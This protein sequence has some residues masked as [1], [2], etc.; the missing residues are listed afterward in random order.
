MVN[1][2]TLEEA[3]RIL[4]ISAEEARKQLKMNNV[5]EFQDP[6]RKTIR[7]PVP[8]VDELARQMGQGSDPQLQLGE[9]RHPKGADSPPPRKKVPE[10]QVDMGAHA[11]SE[12]PSS[13][14]RTAGPK[15]P[16]PK[17]GSDSDVRL[18]ADGSDLDF[19]VASDSDVKMIDES[20]QGPKSGKAGS[21]SG[22]RVIPPERKSDS[23][24]KIVPAG[25][26]GAVPLAASPRKSPSDS[27]IRLQSISKKDGSSDSNLTDE[28]D[29]DEELRKAAERKAKK[30]QGPAAAGK[31]PAGAAYELSEA[32]VNLD[33]SKEKDSSDD[34]VLTPGAASS[35]SEIELSSSELRKLAP[36]EEVSLGGAPSDSGINLHD[37]A[38]SGVSLEKKGDSSDEGEFELSL[39]SGSKPSIKK[40]KKPK[41]E[42]SSSEFEL[43]LEGQP[44]KEPDSDS[45]FELSLDVEGSPT[46][47]SS[48]S[49][50]ELTLDDSGGLAPI[51]EEQK[52][53]IFATDFEVPALEDESGQQAAQA[54]A[55][56][57]LES[58]D[59]DIA[60]DEGDAE[61]EDAESGSQ[62]VALDDEAE[63]D[64]GAATVAR[65][66]RAAGAAALD[67]E[68]EVDELLGGEPE[69]EE[70]DE[71]VGAGAAVAAEPEPWG[72][73]PAIGLG[74]T[75]LVLL[76]VTFISYEQ[77][78][79]MWG[80]RTGSGVSNGITR[81]IGGLVTDLPKE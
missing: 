45:E 73:V 20:A 2:Y 15:S 48:D 27:D 34:F 50:F 21:D 58:S 9:A 42:E 32:D 53:D 47:S 13:K 1:T 43:S 59:F 78:Q 63:A 4:G 28:I 41:K 12:K 6:S 36:E 46:D 30:T 29:L 10:D 67:D 51:D 57:D 37:P 65:P 33:S 35:S 70:S 56:T 75:L 54:E 76:L 74:L 17:K 16:A 62:V 64:S 72:P 79:S 69:P 80:Y 19:K 66:R 3:A 39:D 23:D 60:L 5:R 81:A 26:S 40:D 71:M 8:A 61:K 49:E 68:A 14:K 55:D 7:Y 22:V 25:D 44:K 11:P 52:K 38:D 24:V 18:V 31:L 77:I